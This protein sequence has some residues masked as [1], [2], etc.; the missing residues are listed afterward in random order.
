MVTGSLCGSSGSSG[1]VR[2]AAGSSASSTLGS[3]KSGLQT[4]TS[5]ACSAWSSGV[6]GTGSAG[7]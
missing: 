3:E 2:S 7:S 5:S 1:G 6:V 4:R